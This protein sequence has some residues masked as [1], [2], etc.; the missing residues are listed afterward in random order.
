MRDWEVQAALSTVGPETVR[1]MEGRSNVI[2]CSTAGKVS[3][4]ISIRREWN[5]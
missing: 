4:S 3:T 5:R 1:Y 2:S